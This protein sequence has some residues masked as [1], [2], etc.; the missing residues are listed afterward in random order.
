MSILRHVVGKGVNLIY[1]C[2]GLIIHPT[3]YDVITNHLASCARHT[4]TLVLKY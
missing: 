1:H 2:A 4:A 3:H